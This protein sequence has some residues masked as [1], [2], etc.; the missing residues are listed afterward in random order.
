M[1][2]K[3]LRRGSDFRK[4]NIKM[5]IGDI[6]IPKDKISNYKF[7]LFLGDN[8]LIDKKTNQK[9]ENTN[10]KFLF[11]P[12][13]DEDNGM[14]GF[15]HIDYIYE[16]Q[17]QYEIIPKNKN[18][19]S[20]D[21]R[22]E[23]LSIYDLYGYLNAFLYMG[24]SFIYNNLPKDDNESDYN[25]RNIVFYRSKIF[26]MQDKKIEQL[27]KLFELGKYRIYVMV[28]YVDFFNQIQKMNKE[29]RTDFIIDQVLD[30]YA[31]FSRRREGL[32]SE[33]FKNLMYE[34]D[35]RQR[36]TESAGR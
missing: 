10:G 9:I 5:H 27:E 2:G 7:I 12:F 36:N 23:C 18:E 33:E 20:Y 15:N 19:Q 17:K 31:A 16:I 26:Q 35:G 21:E 3:E 32:S 28:L 30:V 34:I 24:I 4:V 8:T 14:N 13:D 25:E 6:D 11:V 29:K 1:K 22:V